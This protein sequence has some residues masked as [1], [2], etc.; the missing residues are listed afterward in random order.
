MD[1]RI[2]VLTFVT[3]IQVNILVRD[4]KAEE[5]LAITYNVLAESS[6]KNN[7]VLKSDIQSFATTIN[8]NYKLTIYRLA[9]KWALTETFCRRKPT[10]PSELYGP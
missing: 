1:I 5:R 3:G 2:L 10:C 7:L 9:E 8:F 4:T 6:N